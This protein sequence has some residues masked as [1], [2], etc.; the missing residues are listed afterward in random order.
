MEIGCPTTVTHNFKVSRNADGTLNGLPEDWMESLHNQALLDA[1]N[2]DTSAPEAAEQVMD[3]IK[4]YSRDFRSA[5][6]G[7]RSVQQE[8]EE[9]YRAEQS[10][11]EDISSLSQYGRSDDEEKILYDEGDGL[12][13][14]TGADA[15][16]AVSDDG[17]DNDDDDNG[18][19]HYHDA[20]D[21]NNSAGGEEG[22]FLEVADTT[23]EMSRNP[24][25]NLSN[26]VHLKK[27]PLH[28]KRRS[29][30]VSR[31][32]SAAV[33]IIGEEPRIASSTTSPSRPSGY[34][35]ENKPPVPPKPRH[36]SFNTPD[37]T[38]PPKGKLLNK[39]LLRVQ[40][41]TS[42]SNLRAVSKL[43]DKE[44][45]ESLREICSDKPFKFAYNLKEELGEGAGGK[46]MLAVDKETRKQVAVKSIDI[47]DHDRKDHLLMEIKVMRELVHKNLVNYVDL[48]LE[49]NLLLLVMELLPGGALTDV[50][51]YTILL[52]P[53]IAAVTKEVLQ[54]IAYLHKN[55]IVHRDIKSDNI[56]LGEG[57]SIKITDFGFAANVAGNRTRKTFAGTPY[58]MAPEVIN[59]MNYGKGVDI[60]STGIL[61][62]EMQEGKPPFFDE[63]PPQAM[64]YIKT[65][66]RPKM[67]KKIT[68]DFKLF[69]DACMDRKPENRDTAEQLLYHPFLDNTANLRSIVPNIEMARRKKESQQSGFINLMSQY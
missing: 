20:T 1:N 30:S 14:V 44:I 2:G 46:V 4:E 34:S 23:G 60:W 13:E 24:T 27:Q 48:F 32:E 6:G 43:S 26:Y 56:L 31:D 53:Q 25:L 57:G 11:R 17:S 16:A 9:L 19:E 45:F 49:R 36:I 52:E 28:L 62:I 66:G 69:L 33:N 50:V 37:K 63:S 10:I 51:L 54:G 47:R 55:E 40:G 29:K 67:N 5:S 68:Q 22:G 61:C 41:Q 18:D 35:A 7:K 42:R 39:D 8:M 59:N 64:Y 65:K 21:D 12:L 38:M 3:F 58:W 15:A